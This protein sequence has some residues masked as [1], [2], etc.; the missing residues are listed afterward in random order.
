M[1]YPSQIRW[2]SAQKKKKKKD[3]S[4]KIQGSS[5]SKHQRAAKILS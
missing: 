1:Q 2:R 4:D 5:V 3:K